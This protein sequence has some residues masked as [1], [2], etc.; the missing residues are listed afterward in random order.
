MKNYITD[1]QFDKLAPETQL[2]YRYCPH[3]GMF[4]LKSYSKR[5]VC[6]ES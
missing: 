1:E 6:E 4:F 3:C 5:C 2:K